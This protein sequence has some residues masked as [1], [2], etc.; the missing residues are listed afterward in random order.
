MKLIHREEGK[1]KLSPHSLED[2]WYLT[3]IVS[4][5]DIVQGHSFR[6]FKPEDRNRPVEK[7]R[8][9]VHLEIKVDN[10]EFAESVNKLRLTG[11]ILSGTPEEYVSFGEH[12]TLDVELND[13]FVLKKRLSSLEESYLQEA[14]KKTARTKIG[15]VVMYE[16]APRLARI[17]VRGVKFAGEI[18]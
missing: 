10:V 6:T 5:G 18:E 3:K 14:L 12:H 7:D 8:K 16:H 1:L 11:I 4:V 13:S 9:K 15:V 17:D 2:L